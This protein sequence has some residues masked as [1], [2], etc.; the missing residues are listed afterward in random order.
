MSPGTPRRDLIEL[1]GLR[2]LGTHGILAEER[3]RAQLFEVDVDIDLD[4]G[5]AGAS[6]ALSD[7]VDY[8]EVVEAVIAAV[9]GEH[10]DLLEHLAERVAA[11]VSDVAGRRASSVTIALRKLKPPVAADLASAGVR[12]TRPTTRP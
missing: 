4:L 7:S 2:V 10:A 11:A 6:D 3:T 1:R 5:S 9:G 12:I 8:S